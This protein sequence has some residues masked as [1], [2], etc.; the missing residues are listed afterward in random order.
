MQRL[1]TQEDADLPSG[2]TIEIVATFPQLN[3]EMRCGQLG[4]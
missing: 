3:G 4:G 2:Q 1:S